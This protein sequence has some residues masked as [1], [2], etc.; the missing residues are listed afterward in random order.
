MNPIS[1]DKYIT[2]VI[3]GL[4]VIMSITGRVYSCISADFG[5]LNHQSILIRRR[6]TQLTIYIIA[7]NDAVVKKLLL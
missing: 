4:L 6:E 3:L 7:D 2:L 1:L 5:E